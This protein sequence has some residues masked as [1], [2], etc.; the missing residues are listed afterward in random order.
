MNGPCVV[1][2]TRRGCHL[3]HG[4]LTL[5]QRAR[6]H[7]PFVLEVVDLDEEA[8]ADKRAAYD[9]EVPVVELNGRKIMKYRVDEAR[10][11]RL[12]AQASGA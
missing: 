10:L 1:L 5:L 2:Y 11:L 6:V 4:A 9:W 12:L 8:A 7:H 3:C